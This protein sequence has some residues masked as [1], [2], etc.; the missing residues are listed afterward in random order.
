MN[1]GTLV[2]RPVEAERLDAT[3]F[4]LVGPMP[5]DEDW[6]FQPGSVVR[7]VTRTFLDGTQALVAQ[8]LIREA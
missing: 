1:E 8:E 5:E 7:C 6:Q 3:G 2:W 4:R